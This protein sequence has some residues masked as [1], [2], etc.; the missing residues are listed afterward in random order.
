[1]NNQLIT[2]L[3]GTLTPFFY[4]VAV[5]DHSKGTTSYGFGLRVEDLRQARFCYL[6]SLIRSYSLTFINFSSSEYNWLMN[7]DEMQLPT[8]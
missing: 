1:M 4:F 8:S 5:N 7:V 2:R 3:L 6:C